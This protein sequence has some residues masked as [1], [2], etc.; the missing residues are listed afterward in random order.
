MAQL[1]WYRSMS[2]VPAGVGRLWATAMRRSVQHQD[3][4][5]ETHWPIGTWRTVALRIIEDLPAAAGLM[6]VDGS[7]I[8]PLWLN[9]P[10]DDVLD[11][12]REAR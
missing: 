5:F 4:F 9:A 1:A 12:I 3:L 8:G 7:P 2:S 6:F 11:Q 10:A